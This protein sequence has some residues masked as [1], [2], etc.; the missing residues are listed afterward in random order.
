MP[1]PIPGIPHGD[2]P[3][4][5]DVITDPI[6]DAVC[7]IAPWLPGCPPTGNGNGLPGIPPPN[8][9]GGPGPGPP[10]PSNGGALSGGRMQQ[11]LYIAGSCAG[12]WHD[13]PVYTRYD[14]VTGVPRQV[15]G[16]RRANP[17]SIAQDASGALQFFAPVAPSGWRLKYKT[18]R[19]RHHHHRK[20][21]VRHH[22]HRKKRVAHHHHRRRGAHGLTAKQLKAGFGGKHHM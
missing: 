2:F 3:D 11:S 18:R 16:N 20:R 14:P 17:I 13:T 5:L 6:T 19:A 4:P 15:G 7:A 21:A 22:H 12:L 1:F 8:G 9:N 10:P